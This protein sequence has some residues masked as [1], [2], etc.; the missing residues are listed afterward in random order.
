MKTILAALC[1]L[2]VLFAGGCAVLLVR[3]SGGGGLL[4]FA[5]IPLCIA[6][7][8]VAALLALCG[9]ARLRAWVFSLLALLDVAAAAIMGLFWLSVSFQVKDIWTIA[10]PAIAVLLV[11]AVLTVLVAWRLP[12][13]GSPPQG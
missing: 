12:S 3:E 5:L 2:A 11:K 1:G 7:L 6:A 9:R 10:A 8:N 4:P 13:A